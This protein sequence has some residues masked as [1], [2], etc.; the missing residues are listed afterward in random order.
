MRSLLIL[1]TAL[2]A[3]VAALAVPPTLSDKAKP[4][5]DGKTLDG[6][7]SPTADLWRVQD[8]ELTG[9]N[10]KKVPHNDFLC[11]KA[12]YANFILRLQIKL[13]GDPKTGMINSG[14]Q[15]RSKRVP[16]SAE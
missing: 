10:G 6:W 13:T 15:I 12:S 8:G 2:F 4:L 16:G 3:S 1:V 5:F 14:V 7:E 11:T 9:G